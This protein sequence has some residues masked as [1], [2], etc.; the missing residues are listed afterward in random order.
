[1]PKPTRAEPSRSACRRAS[2]IISRVGPPP[3]SPNPNGMSDV[4]EPPWSAKFS[5]L[6]ASSTGRMSPL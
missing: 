3:P 2:A 1:M 4:E 6:R 5:T